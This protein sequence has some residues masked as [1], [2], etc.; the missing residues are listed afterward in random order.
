MWIN[1]E[2]IAILTILS[3]LIHKHKMAFHLFIFRSYL[4]SLSNF[5]YFN[6]IRLIHL[7]SDLSLTNSWFLI[8]RMVFFNF[9][10]LNVYCK[11]REIQLI[12]PY[13]SYVLQPRLI[14]L[15][16][17]VAFFFGFMRLSLQ[18]IMSSVN[19][20]LHSLFHIDFFLLFS[21]L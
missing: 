19:T 9:Q 6:C 8:L 4:N 13:W 3:F 12:F 20:V 10:F 14:Y 11:Y 2:S 5:F 7:F 1:L 18:M 17:L 15:L 21:V 16:V